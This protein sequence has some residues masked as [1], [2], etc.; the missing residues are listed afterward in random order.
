MKN[1]LL[2]ILLPPL[3]MLAWLAVQNAWRRVFFSLDADGDVL[4]GRSTCGHCGCAVPCERRN[5]KDSS[6]RG[7]SS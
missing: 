6:E 3:L 1:Y 2:A 7:T 5:N 4:A